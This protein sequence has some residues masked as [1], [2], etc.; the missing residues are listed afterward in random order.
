MYLSYS[1]K[2]RDFNG[3]T[4]IDNIN[5][6]ENKKITFLKYFSVEIKVFFIIDLLYQ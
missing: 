2:K 1:E 3:V 5:S 6:I 4:E